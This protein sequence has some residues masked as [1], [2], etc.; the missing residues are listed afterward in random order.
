VAAVLGV[1]AG[2][3]C[4]V[5]SDVFYVV[6]VQ[7]LWPHPAKFAY[8]LLLPP[9]ERFSNRMYK[10]AML[11]DLFSDN[12]YIV[13]VLYVCWRYKLHEETW[14]RFALFWAFQS[15][16]IV[17]HLHPALLDDRYGHEDFIYWL[18]CPCGCA[19]MAVLDLSPLL[20]PDAIR[21]LVFPREGP[22]LALAAA[23]QRARSG[24]EAPAEA[25][26]QQQA[27]SGV[28][29][30]GEALRAAAESPASSGGSA[31]SPSPSAS[32]ASG[33][34]PDSVLPPAVTV[35][36]DDV[37][38][39]RALCFGGARTQSLLAQPSPAPLS[40]LLRRRATQSLAASA[41]ELRGGG[42][43]ECSSPKRR[44]RSDARL[45]AH[46]GARTP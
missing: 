7:L 46:A 39:L 15:L 4:H 35:P 21:V 8:P 19:F 11:G 2:A 24:K 17:A 22:A 20:L 38:A 12:L 3:V 18:F 16:V 27:L 9:R 43:D 32:A 34:S 44:S 31:P 25:A 14:R 45:S 1:A 40:S 36:D 28:G 29:D 10:L 26:A 30:A 6:P 13:P 37:A 23:Q 33:P 5:L 41:G 42:D